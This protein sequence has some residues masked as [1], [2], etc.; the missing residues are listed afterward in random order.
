MDKEKMENFIEGLR[1]KVDDKLLDNLGFRCYFSIIVDEVSSYDISSDAKQ[2][3]F[4][5]KRDKDGFERQYFSI[6][7]ELMLQSI[8][9]GRI[10]KEQ[11]GYREYHGY[12][13]RFFDENGFLYES[14]FLDNSCLR[15]RTTGIDIMCEQ[16]P[17]QV[18]SPVN[19]APANFLEIGLRG[20]YKFNEGV[21]K[22]SVHKIKYSRNKENPNFIFYEYD[23]GTNVINQACSNSPDARGE[24]TMMKPILSNPLACYDKVARKLVVESVYGDKSFEQ[25]YNDMKF[26]EFSWTSAYLPEGQGKSR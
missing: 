15:S 14:V 25:L 26:S 18:M 19:F 20:F 4:D 5:L 21:D 23:N 17:S 9:E 22:K 8:Y 11:E 1:G 12:G 16:L 2:I 6:D 7:G 24:M 3:R 10:E 13:K